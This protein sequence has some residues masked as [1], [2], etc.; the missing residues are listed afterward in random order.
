MTLRYDISEA[1]WVRLSDEWFL[2]S[3][4]GQRWMRWFQGFGIVGGL[5]LLATLYALQ[6][7]VLSWAIV[8]AAELLWRLSLPWQLRRQFRRHFR[9]STPDW[10]EVSVETEGLRVRQNDVSF[11]SVWSQVTDP[12]VTPSAVV[13]EYLGAC[14][15]VPRR[16]LDSAGG[17]AWFVEAVL[18]AKGAGAPTTTLMPLGDAAAPHAVTI[19]RSQKQLVDAT[20]ELYPVSPEL[21]RKWLPT[22]I[23]ASVGTWICGLFLVFP[24]LTFLW[25]KNLISMPNGWQYIGYASLL[26]ILQFGLFRFD[27]RRH[28]AAEAASLWKDERYRQNT[29]L[30][31]TVVKEGIRIRGPL[32][33]SLREWPT[34]IACHE[35][36]HFLHLRFRD[37]FFEIPRTAFASEEDARNFVALVE[38]RGVA[39]T[40]RRQIS[41]DAALR[42]ADT[43]QTIQR[44]E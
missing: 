4:A 8:I 12:T 41:A 40:P 3:L 27:L 7:G 28:A 23:I 37:A 44:G 10:L 2:P 31:I 34:L 30:T 20:V 17:V 15:A 13:L 5:V 26:G 38:A 1:D 43:Q 9:A 33:E 19:E 25:S 39:E 29:P 18:R 14:C 35:T 32:A 11:L 24:I 21:R 22:R 36:R 42:I 6:V 16:V